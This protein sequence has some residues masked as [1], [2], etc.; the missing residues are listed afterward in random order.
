MIIIPTINIT[1]ITIIIIPIIIIVMNSIFIITN[2]D[3]EN[4]TIQHYG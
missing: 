4:I 2:N 3:G 1:T